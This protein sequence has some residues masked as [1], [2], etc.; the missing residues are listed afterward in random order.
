MAGTGR[1]GKHLRGRVLVGVV[2][3]GAAA[4][5]AAGCAT[6]REPVAGQ[7]AAEAQRAICDDFARGD[8]KRLGESVPAAL[9]RGFM[10]G[11]A[12]DTAWTLESLHSPRGAPPVEAPPDL[13]PLPAA[14]PP[15]AVP[16]FSWA[17]GGAQLARDAARTNEGVYREAVETCMAPARLAEEFGHK[18][19]RVATSLELLAD[20]YGWQHRYAQAEP[21]RREAIAIWEGVFG[22]N[23][24]RVARA[25]DDHARML[26]LLHRGEEADSRSERAVLIRAQVRR[27]APGPPAATAG[28]TSRVSCDSPFAATLFILCRGASHDQDADRHPAIDWP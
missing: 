18:D 9:A 11:L 2:A 16:L 26:R 4:L 13:T 5:H 15:G 27:D 8:V 25:L 24:Q 23:D 7:S 6:Y 10:V 17:V 14:L 22:A 20:C 1:H 21:L 28:R 3:L 12:L 19:A